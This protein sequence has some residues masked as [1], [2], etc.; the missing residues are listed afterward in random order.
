[1]ELKPIKTKDEYEAAL[2]WVDAQFDAGVMPHTLAGEKVA[3]ML[4][5]IQQYED[6]HFPV[7]P[8]VNQ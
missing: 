7:V 8:P 3:K 1:M 2:S 5:G 4:W 6:V